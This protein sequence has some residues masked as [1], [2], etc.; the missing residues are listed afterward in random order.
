MEEGN[1][2]VAGELHVKDGKISYVGT[3]EK[4]EE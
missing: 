4:A 1:D 3:E 2:I